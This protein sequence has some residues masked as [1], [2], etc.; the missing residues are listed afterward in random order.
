MLLSPSQLQVHNV[1]E[2]EG[3]RVDVLEVGDD[4]GKDNDVW[5]NDVE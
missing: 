4:V 2:A 5:L 3:D 1:V